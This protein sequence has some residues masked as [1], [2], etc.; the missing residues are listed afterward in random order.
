MKRTVVRF[1]VMLFAATVIS[2]PA[3][4]VVAGGDGPRWSSDSRQSVASAV[5]ATDKFHSLGEATEAGYALPPA[6]V[7]LHE[8]IASLNNTGG[9]GYHYINGKLLDDVI[10]ARRP[11]VLVFAPDRHGKRRLAALEYVVFQDAWNKAHPNTTPTLFGEPFHATGS[12][13]RYNIPAFYALHVWLWRDNPSGL[14]AD[15]NPTVSCG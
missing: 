13:N 3:M 9:M 7:P 6:G 2:F 1:G 4:A 11:E 8:C 5:H 14:F 10:D 15:F 12:P